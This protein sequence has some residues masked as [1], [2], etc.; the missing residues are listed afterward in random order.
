[1]D[2]IAILLD[3][4]PQL[5][6]IWLGLG[7]RNENRF[8]V[9]T[10]ETRASFRLT[11]NGDLERRAHSVKHVRKVAR[12]DE[13]MA[14]YVRKCVAPKPRVDTFP[15]GAGQQGVAPDERAPAAPARR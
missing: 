7:N 4:T 12:D 6:V 1:M 14:L 2:E 15:L 13:G 5:K 8:D 11:K 9:C 10:I 3:T